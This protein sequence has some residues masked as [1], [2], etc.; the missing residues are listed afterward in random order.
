MHL[1]IQSI[2]IQS[3]RY[4]A[5]KPTK[6]NILSNWKLYCEEDNLKIEFVQV[7]ALANETDSPLSKFYVYF[8]VDNFCNC[9]F[10]WDTFYFEL[11]IG[12][13]E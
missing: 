9:Y 5:R 4:I 11:V 7:V 6:L 12:I 1:G 2:G 8:G 10:G 13:K 3:T